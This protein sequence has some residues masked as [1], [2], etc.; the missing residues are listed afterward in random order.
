MR[1]PL[2]EPL[3]DVTPPPGGPVKANLKQGLPIEFFACTWEGAQDEVRRSRECD[4]W[5]YDWPGVDFY[6]LFGNGYWWMQPQ[7]DHSPLARRYYD[8]LTGDLNDAVNQAYNQCESRHYATQ[9][10][11]KP[12][13]RLTVSSRLGRAGA[14]RDENRPRGIEARLSVPFAAGTTPP[15]PAPCPMLPRELFSRPVGFDYVLHGPGGG[16]FR[17]DWRDQPT[18]TPDPY[19]ELYG[20]TLRFSGSVGSQF[21]GNLH[22]V[23]DRLADL[24]L[25]FESRPIPTAVADRVDPAQ[26]L[27]YQVSQG[28]GY[29]GFAAVIEVVHL[30]SGQIY[31]ASVHGPNYSPGQMT[32]YNWWPSGW[33]QMSMD[34][35]G[36]IRHYGVDW[37]IPIYAIDPTNTGLPATGTYRMQV[38]LLAYGYQTFNRSVTS[39]VLGSGG[40]T[41]LSWK[42]IFLSHMPSLISYTP[43]ETFG[44]I[45]PFEYTYTRSPV[46][47]PWPADGTGILFDAVFDM[48][49]LTTFRFVVKVRNTFDFAVGLVVQ[50]SGWQAWV[51]LQPGETKHLA[52][53]VS[54]S[55]MFNWNAYPLHPMSPTYGWERSWGSSYISMYNGQCTIPFSLFLTAPSP[56]E[57]TPANLPALKATQRWYWDLSSWAPQYEP[58]WGAIKKY[59]TDGRYDY[60]Y[61]LQQYNLT[62]NVITTIYRGITKPSYQPPIDPAAYFVTGY[63]TVLYDWSSPWHKRPWPGYSGWGSLSAP[64]MVNGERQTWDGTQYVWVPVEAVSI[65]LTRAMMQQVAAQLGVTEYV[66][67]DGDDIRWFVP[68]AYNPPTYPESFSNVL[69]IDR[70]YT[71]GGAL[72]DDAAM[73]N[74]FQ[75]VITNNAG[76]WPNYRNLVVHPSVRFGSFLDNGGFEVGDYLLGPN[77]DMVEV[78]SLADLGSVSTRFLYHIRPEFQ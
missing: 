66:V 65:S 58:E 45:P 7:P 4:W 29:F 13:M 71:R 53:G 26:P 55:G 25:R 63:Q 9:S 20:R 17:W 1:A 11:P 47:Y 75:T 41:R 32:A 70:F 15:P 72:I 5:I 22:L 27:S 76:A 49:N 77:G 6:W 31:S 40:D 73:R 59:A 8:Q 50:A 69:W 39:N 42:S 68:V 23:I 21:L 62:A 12:G 3:P 10:E 44:I 51:I 54:I 30:E 74:A 35:N 38:I 2:P 43:G 33:E 34:A 36:I 14:R 60:E 52:G 37:S 64:I 48:K 57:T 19:F 24:W 56:P 18:I 28:V 46:L 67:M 16:N 61:V 78:G